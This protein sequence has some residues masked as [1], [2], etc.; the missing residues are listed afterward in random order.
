MP[1]LHPKSTPMVTLN[2]LMVFFTITYLGR[3]VTLV[4]SM[5]LDRKVVG[6]NPILAATPGTLA[7]LSNAPFTGKL[8][9]YRGNKF[10]RGNCRIC[11]I[12]SYGTAG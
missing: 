3:D 10:Y 8:D 9:F 5:P 2:H 4:K 1:G 11:V 6:S 12:R 7:S